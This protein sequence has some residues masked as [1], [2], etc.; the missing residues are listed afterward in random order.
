MTDTPKKIML[1]DDDR[2]LLDM[3]AL[4]FKNAGCEPIVAVGAA[5]ALQKLR[6]GLIP[7]AIVLDIIMPAVDGLELLGLIRKENLAEKAV[8]VMLTNESDQEKKEM[9]KN[10]GAASY[11]IKATT[12]PS[13]VVSQV[14]ALLE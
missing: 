9:A 12:I 5:D 11:I 13:E 2:F 6:G 7:D 4:K 10:L 1:I 14:K 3:Y 8:V